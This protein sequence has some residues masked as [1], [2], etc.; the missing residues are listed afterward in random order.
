[1]KQFIPSTIKSGRLGNEYPLHVD[2]HDDKYFV[3]YEVPVTNQK[4]IV[5]KKRYS[6]TIPKYI[7]LDAE[8]LE[9]I[10]LLQGEMSKAFRRTLTFA[11]SEPGILRKVMFW[12]EKSNFT[13]KTSWRWYIRVNLREP[14]NKQEVEQLENQVIAQWLDIGCLRRE[15]LNPKAVSYVSSTLNKALDGIGTVMIERGDQSL[16]RQCSH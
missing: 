4:G 6:E 8:T 15:E 9:V 10:G 13:G 2:E 7:E 16:F 11:N 1:M 3:W 5:G 14:E 12:F